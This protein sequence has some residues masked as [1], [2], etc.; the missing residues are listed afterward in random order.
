MED[1][2]RPQTYTLRFE[3]GRFALPFMV[4]HYHQTRFPGHAEYALRLVFDKSPYRQKVQ[5]NCPLS[6]KSSTEEVIYYHAEYKEF[7]SHEIEGSGG[8]DWEIG[9]CIVN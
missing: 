8:S 5:G 7:V 3:S 1:A 4:E 6:W 9:K 2:Y